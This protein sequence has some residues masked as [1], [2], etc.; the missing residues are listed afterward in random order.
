MNKKKKNK[1]V[2]FRHKVALVFFRP[3]L[4]PVI[5]FKYRYRYKKYKEY[6]NKG[7]VLILGNHAIGI[8]PILIAYSFPNL[9]YYFATEQIFNLGILSKFLVYLVNPISKSKEGSDISSIKKAKRIVDEGGSIGLYPEGNI[10]Y[11][12]AI[13]SI[14]ISVV[15]LIRLLKIDVVIYTTRGLYLSNPRWSINR[16]RGKTYGEITKIITKEEYDLLTNEELYELVVDA[17]NVNAYEQQEERLLP[18]KGRKLANGLDKLVFMDLNTGEPFVTYSDNDQLKSRSSNFTLTYDKYGYVTDELGVRTT[19]IDIHHRVIESYN[20]YYH[21]DNNN[22]LFA[23]KALVEITTKS[24]KHSRGHN[25]IELFKDGVI[26]NFKDHVDILKFD[27]INTLALQG[28]KRIIIN[29]REKKYL[30]TFD[31]KA[32]TYKYLLTYQFFKKG[33]I[34]GDSFSVQQ[35]GL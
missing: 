18:Y 14:N 2:K 34:K 33:D 31:V 3:L 12:G 4:W 7:P 32:C 22:F 26:I 29:T 27:E 17:L 25:V 9:L 13:N 21:Q 30:I 10:S 1:E 23:D 35:F 15:K 19:L 24:K 6:K 20:K 16:K 8:D 11:D 28:K 5:Q